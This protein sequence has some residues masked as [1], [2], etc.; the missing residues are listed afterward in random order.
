LPDDGIDQDAFRKFEHDGWNSL[1]DGY[2]DHWEHLT[3]QIIPLMLERTGVGVGSLVLDIA[4]G[5]GYAAGAAAAMGARAIG[6]DLAENMRDLAAANFPDAAFQLGDAEDLPFAGDSFDVVTM[7]FGV[8]HFPDAEKA[9]AETFRVLKPGGRL[10]FTAWEGPEGS[11]L[12]MATAAIV[13]EGTVK[14]DLPQGTPIFRF[15]E[16]AECARVLGAIG[17]EDIASTN[18]MLT[19]HLPRADALMESFRQATARMSALLGAQDPAKLPAIK[20]AMTE[21]CKPFDN[22]TT[23]DLPMPAVLTVGRKP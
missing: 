8:L 9:L 4:S 18:T 7:N 1:S 17:F 6:I 3:P 2:H 12:G 21:A 14:V 15:A 11:A 16:H 22:G 5:P 10:G 20:A 19:W 23:T 13:Q